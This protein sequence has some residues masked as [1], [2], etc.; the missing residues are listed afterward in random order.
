M[1]GP[2]KRRRKTFWW[3]VPD[4]WR[5]IGRHCQWPELLSL[6]MTCQA[7]RRVLHDDVERALGHV[8]G[9]FE[10]LILD[11]RFSFTRTCCHEIQSGNDSFSMFVLPKP[12]YRYRVTQFLYKILPFL[13]REGVDIQGVYGQDFMRFL[14]IVGLKKGP[15][16]PK[17]SRWKKELTSNH[18]FDK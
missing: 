15:M 11:I 5:L 6:S 9:Y 8:H 3:P 12:W 1:E 2:R 10:R 16:N 4:F 7:A 14:R 18:G 13:E 17:W